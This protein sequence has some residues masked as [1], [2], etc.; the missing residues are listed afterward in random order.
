MGTPASRQP[1]TTRSIFYALG[2]NVAIGV[3][4]ACGAALTG[5]GALLAESFHSLADTANEVLL[6]LGRKQAKL[7]PSARHP[8]G[9]GRETYF[10]SFVVTILLFSVGGI[11]SIYEGVR[12]VYEPATIEKPWIGVAILLF[13][14]LAEGL[15]L[16]TVLTQVGKVRGERSLWSWF[17]ETR[18]SELIV[19][20]GEDLAAIA[21]L[22][23]ALPALLVTIVTGNTIYDAIGSMAIGA[24]LMI[25]A[26]GLA[27]E[28]K[29]LLIGE[30]ASPGTRRALRRFLNSRPQILEIGELVT[31]QHGDDLIVAIT[32]HMKNTGTSRELVGTIAEC[33][34]AVQAA[35]P[36]IRWI[37]FEPIDG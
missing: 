27:I 35:F 34:A 2:A 9:H 15:S 16:R 32:A 25:V 21:G 24:L 28:I 17:R 5:S 31:L 1:D 3:S 8:L 36:Q 37:F 18:R 7:R 20:L 30:S 4:K 19:V 33:K 6:L 29:S 12:K 14:M 22:S 11:F 13:A 10:W 23:V 26:S